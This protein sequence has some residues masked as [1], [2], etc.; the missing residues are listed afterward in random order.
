MGTLRR[1]FVGEDWLYED[2]NGETFAFRLA[3]LW[4]NWLYRYL[5]WVR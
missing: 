3:P 4:L 5:P 2:P 1:F